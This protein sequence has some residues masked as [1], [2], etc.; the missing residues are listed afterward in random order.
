MPS[1]IDTIPQTTSDFAPFKELLYAL[2]VVNKFTKV[3]E[4][5]TDVGDSTR[6]FSTALQAT[7][8]QLV[9]ID[10]NATV[11]NG[12]AK[13]W[14]IKNVQFVTGDSRQL[15]LTQEIDLLFL[16]AHL[17]G[18]NG[19]DQIKAELTTLGGWVRAGGKIVIDDVFHS[20][21]GE[22]IRK[23]YEEFCRA[24]LLAWTVYPHSHGLVVIEVTHPLPHA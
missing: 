10:I 18:T 12:W 4:T 1:P 16:D 8:G 15:K 21:F 17:P 2:V 7:Q 22:G 5:G 3:L 6:I 24:N 20:E 13:D 23:A 14:P 9:T 11:V 19:Y